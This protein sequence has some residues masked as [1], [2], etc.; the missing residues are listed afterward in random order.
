MR[1][2]SATMRSFVCGPPQMA[3][4]MAPYSAGGWGNAAAASATVGI[5]I[6]LHGWAAS[7]A[8]GKND[9][10]AKRRIVFMGGDARGERGLIDE[11]AGTT[12]SAGRESR[13]ET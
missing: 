4:W 10:N 6:S 5:V 1:S 2:M 8:S 12:G 11:A 9:S 13:R 3:Q 7:S